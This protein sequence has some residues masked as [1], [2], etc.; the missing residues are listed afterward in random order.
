MNCK[1]E[2]SALLKQ[3]MKN[4]SLEAILYGLTNLVEYLKLSKKLFFI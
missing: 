1:S 4:I 3:C 2:N